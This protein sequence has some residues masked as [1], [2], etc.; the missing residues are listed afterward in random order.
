MSYNYVIDY[1]VN[2]TMVRGPTVTVIKVGLFLIELLYSSLYFSTSGLLYFTSLPV[3]LYC[4]DK[5]CKLMHV[6]H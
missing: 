6:F 1:T 3:S 5:E 4:D 2:V